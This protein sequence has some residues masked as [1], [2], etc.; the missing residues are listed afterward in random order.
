MEKKELKQKISLRS[1]GGLSKASLFNDVSVGLVK[2]I[3]Q[4][5]DFGQTMKLYR[6]MLKRDAQISGD[7]LERNL[8]LTGS[9]WHIEGDDKT[10]NEFAKSW[11]DT[12]EFNSLL[13]DLCS[14][15]SYGFSLVD[16]V[17]GNV[18]IKN[19]TYFLPVKF[20][21]IEPTLI[22]EDDKKGLFIQDSSNTK[23]FIDE[24]NL[25]VIMHKHKIQSGSLIEQSAIARLIWIFTLKHFIV[26]QHMSFAE[27][28]GVPP[29]IVNSDSSDKEVLKQLFD[30]V[31]ELRSGSAGVFS[32]DSKVSLME[33]KG[34]G[35][36]FMKF[37]EYADNAIT[38]NI[39]GGTMSSANADKGSYGRDKAHSDLRYKFHKADARLIASTLERLLKMACDMNLNSVK[40][41]PKFAFDLAQNS[42]L[43]SKAN[44]LKT[45]SEIGFSEIPTAHIHDTFGI[46]YAK[47]S[48]VV[49][50]KIEKNARKAL[51]HIDTQ[52][53]TLDTTKLGDTLQEAV[54]KSLDEANS[55]EEALEILDS[56]YNDFDLG[57]IER[58]LNNHL[59]NAELQGAV[60]G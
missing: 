1:S 2:S 3:L 59:F 41:Y 29:I 22:Q 25:K 30:Q 46:P 56:E 8:T 13:T 49:K 27:L 37:V 11:L 14:G 57:E 18:S 31:F 60:D 7:L 20:A 4:S 55:Y 32:K 53:N 47:N 16:I 36:L 38:R 24:L 9:D 58:A 50:A 44:V 52:L 43:E 39:L 35:E 10:T 33:G 12:I 26:A 28:L 51:D 45:L 42:D 48:K 54:I 15:I 5:G 34:N 19:K 40:E 6:T 23:H 21:H 17:W